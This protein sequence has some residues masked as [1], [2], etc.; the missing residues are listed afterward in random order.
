[1]KRIRYVWGRIERPLLL[2][3]VFVFLC[4]AWAGMYKFTKIVLALVR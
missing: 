1:M 2:L 4:A 3:L